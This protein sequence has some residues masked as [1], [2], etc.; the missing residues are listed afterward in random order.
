MSFI[1]VGYRLQVNLLVTHKHIHYRRLLVG[2]IWI[3]P[4][5]L[6]WLDELLCVYCNWWFCGLIVRLFMYRQYFKYFKLC[7]D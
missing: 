7:L 1:G 2:H 5:L 3:Y 4:M 6:K